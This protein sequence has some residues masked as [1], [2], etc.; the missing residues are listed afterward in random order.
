[1]SGLARNAAA[2]AKLME[3]RTVLAAWSLWRQAAETAMHSALTIQARLALIGTA[4]MTGKEY[5]WAEMSLMVLEKQQ[6][7]MDSAYAAW[8][9]NPAFA[10]DPRAALR[11]STAGLRPYRQKTRSNARRLSK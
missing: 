6:A 1:M 2:A 3:P 11:M 10:T 5:P 8:R 7:V 9:A 4:M